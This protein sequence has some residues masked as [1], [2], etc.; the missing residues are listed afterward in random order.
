MESKWRQNVS[1]LGWNNVRDDVRIE[2]A[3]ELTGLPGTFLLCENFYY[4]A[5]RLSLYVPG[6]NPQELGAFAGIVP[7]TGFPYG[8]FV[9][10]DSG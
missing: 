6:G 8:F 2:F 5:R 7:P 9:E 1:D 3:A 4:T 10:P